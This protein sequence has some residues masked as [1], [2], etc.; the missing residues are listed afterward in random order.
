[1]DRCAADLEACG[2]LKQPGMFCEGGI[3]LGFQLLKQLVFV[4]GSDPPRTTRGRANAVQRAELMLDQVQLHRLKM[5]V[6]LSRHIR[7]GSA[8]HDSLDDAFT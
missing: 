4:F 7:A 5:D 6:K 8:R 3:R 1:V 2:F